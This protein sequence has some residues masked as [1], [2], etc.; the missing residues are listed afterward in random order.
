MSRSTRAVAALIVVVVAGGCNASPA[1]TRRLPPAPTPAPAF[2]AALPGTW[3][4]SMKDWVG[5]ADSMLVVQAD[6]SNSLTYR[7]AGRPASYDWYNVSEGGRIGVTSAS[8]NT[9]SFEFVSP[10]IGTQGPYRW[11]GDFLG[12]FILDKS[13][14]ETLSG[15]YELRGWSEDCFSPPRKG[16]FSFVREAAR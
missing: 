8:Q 11:A 3:R 4:G 7:Y 1:S 2:R 9:V 13:G 14:K 5:T 6:G 10:N 15:T 16:T 12:A